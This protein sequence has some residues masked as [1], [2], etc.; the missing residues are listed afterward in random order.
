MESLNIE[1]IKEYRK[2][3]LGNE[4]VRSWREDA[5]EIARTCKGMQGHASKDMQGTELK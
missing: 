2:N 4:H 1:G 3:T 5:K